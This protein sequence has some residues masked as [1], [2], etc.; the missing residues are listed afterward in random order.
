MADTS[1]NLTSLDYD[2][3]KDDLRNF[4]RSTGE[5]GD[6]DF[7]QG[8]LAAILKVLAYSGWKNAWL[9][10]MMATESF[11]DTAQRRTSILSHA[12]EL[13][14]TPRSWRSAKATVRFTWTRGDASEYIIE[15]G[16]QFASLSSRAG[17]L[18]FSVAETTVVTSKTDQFT[19]DLDIYEGT[20]VSD[21]YLM[22]DDTRF[23]IGNERV[24]TDSISVGVYENSSET[25]TTYTKKT[26][27]LGLNETHKVWFLQTAETGQYEVV[28]GDGVLGY[29][30]KNG[31]RIVIDYRVTRGPDGNGASIFT[32]SFNPNPGDAE[33]LEVE[34][35]DVAAGGAEPE[36]VESIRFRA[37]RHFRVQ[38]RA[39]TAEDYAILLTEQFPEILDAYAYG[40][41]DAD[42][43][44]YGKVF[45]LVVLDEVDGLPDSRRIAYENF[46]KSRCSL[47]VRPVVMEPDRTYI[48]V[49]TRIYY[50]PSLSASP[51]STLVAAATARIIQFGE[52]NVNGFGKGL[53][54]SRLTAYIDDTDDSFLSN[55]TSIILFKSMSPSLGSPFNTDFHFETELDRCP[56]ELDVQRFR[57]AREERTMWSD[58]FTW[59]GNITATLSDDGDGGVWVAHQVGMR[60]QLL[61]QVGEI[62]YDKG[63]VKIRG[64]TVENYEGEKIN[65]YVEAREKNVA[66][67]LKSILTFSSDMITVEMIA[68]NDR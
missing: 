49:A 15:K 5:F 47:T 18:L 21:A 28:F 34:T 35:I 52:D 22:N 6:Y 12:K 29:R 56:S 9:L 61:K 60:T 19:V 14:Y 50:D 39:T 23:I 27:L 24:D 53:R 10:N 42:P 54:F 32:P 30:P 67:N 48:G 45:V 38:E 4:L 2:T 3:L 55:E 11:L 1:L 51:V 8:T 25:P 37:P 31:S 63:T 36:S 62:D 7:E 57:S 16:H 13:N 59:A 33:D 66:A 26:S 20:Y 40:G 58:P 46:L 64:L 43:P 68:V 65:V 17:A 41:E 44:Q